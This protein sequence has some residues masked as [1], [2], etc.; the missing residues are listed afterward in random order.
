MKQV[1]LIIITHNDNYLLFKRSKLNHQFINLYGLVGGEIED[2]ETPEE[3]AKREAKEEINLNLPKLKKVKKYIYKHN[4]LN[5]FYTE[6]ENIDDIELNAEHTEFKE[7]TLD[8]IIDNKEVIPTTIK[9]I[10]DYLDKSNIVKELYGSSDGNDDILSDDGN[11]FDVI[12]NNGAGVDMFANQVTTMDESGTDRYTSDYGVGDS[13][14]SAYNVEH[15]DDDKDNYSNDELLE[16]RTAWINGSIGVGVKQKCRLGGGSI[17]NQGDINNLEF[18]KLSLNEEEIPEFVDVDNIKRSTLNSDGRTIFSNIEG[19]INF[20]NWF[21][22]SKVVD[23]LGRPLV[24]YHGTRANFNEFKPSGKIG[25]QG[26]EDQIEG[27]YFTDNKKG[28]GF[29]SLND[30]SKYLKEVYLSINNPYTSEGNA[31]LKR[32]LGVENLGNVAEKVQNYGNDG[33]ILERGFYAQGGPHKLFLAFSPSQIKSAIGNN[34]KFDNSNSIINEEFDPDNGYE[35]KDVINAVINGTKGVGVEMLTPSVKKIIIDNDLNIIMVSPPHHDLYIIYKD[36]RDKALKV[37]NYLKSHNGYFNDKT[38]EDAWEIGKLLDYTEDSIKKFIKRV[39][40]DKVNIYGDKYPE[41]RYPI[42]MV[43]DPK[44]IEEGVTNK[45][46]EKKY[47]IEPEFSDFENKYNNKQSQDNNE[48][49]IYKRGNFIIIKNPKTLNNIWPN[50]RGVIDKEGNIYIQ[51]TTVIVHDTILQ[52]LNKLS[53]IKYIEHWAVTLP[54]EFVTIQRKENTNTFV[55]GD[56]NYLMTNHEYNKYM[57]SIDEATPIYQ[58]F[59]YRA[60]LKNP[61]YSF[62]NEVIEYNDGLDENAVSTSCQEYNITPEVRDYILKFDSSEKLLRSG[63]IPTDILDLMAFGFNDKTLK[64]IM[65]KNLSIKWKN[66]LDN[67]IYEIEKSGLSKYQWAKKINLTEPIEVSYNGK[68][69]YIEDGHHRYYAAKILNLPL[70]IDLEIKANPIMKLDGIGDYEKFHRSLWNQVHNNNIEEGVADKYAEKFGIPNEDNIFNTLYNSANQKNIEKPVGVS[71]GKLNRFADEK[72]SIEIYKNPKSLNNFDANVR[73]ISDINGNL[74]VTIFDGEINHGNI[75]T[76]I[77]IDE[78]D[79]YD[80]QDEYVLLH[81]INKTN[82]FGLSDMSEEAYEGNYKEEVINILENVKMHNPQYEY[83]TSFYTHPQLGEPI[84]IKEGIADKY[85]KNMNENEENNSA[86]K[87]ND[88]VN[89]LRLSPFIKELINNNAD[90]Y[91]VGGA[92]RDLILNKPNKD[93]DLV[94]RKIPIDNLISILDKFGKV[95]VVG[96]SFGVIKFIDSDGID[97]DIALPRREKPNGE[98]GYKGFEI[99]N[100]ENL[101]IEDDLTRRDSR[102]NAMAINI[103]TGN[104]IDP[105]GG[106]NDIEN[107]QISAANPEAFS[108]DPLRMLRMVGFASRFGFTIEPNTMQMIINNA[109]RIK[110]I[111]ADRI[112]IEFDKIVKNNK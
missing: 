55:L 32:S 75:A 2:G 56:S 33:I 77:G 25:N 53:L 66:D 29:F 65:P 71:Y 99:Q 16:R 57:P 48:N 79:L 40:V 27:M 8:E 106:L 38:P 4:I 111:P 96:K 100:D 45:Y 35:A 94:I 90:I 73:A 98:G 81:R 101:P 44:F 6:I 14:Y 74:Y 87:I 60:K 59:L 49:I 3:A 39:Y 37:Y 67:V 15:E 36:Q 23:E 108:D 28:A 43:V 1:S 112:L 78:Y 69:F 42:D 26:E 105:L 61:K 83:F 63:G 10:N 107:K 30:N 24:V 52:I 84:S 104:F 20:W 54:T 58:Q 17:C 86:P 95:D 22:N 50:A 110:E 47:G 51:N 18:S 97:Y 72:S 5:V 89:K 92:T 82:S 11:V 46:L 88:F 76:A 41:D 102:M 68:K 7:F 80:A 85:G 103:N 21:G 13:K 64:K 12:K 91:V 70:N 62:V 19:I 34:G 31:E 109:S 9:M 93:I